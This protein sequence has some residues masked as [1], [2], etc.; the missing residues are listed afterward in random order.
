MVHKIRRHPVH[1]LATPMQLSYSVWDYCE[2]VDL[3]P[4]MIDHSHTVAFN[5]VR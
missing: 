2:L 4:T 1:P 5:T 3:A